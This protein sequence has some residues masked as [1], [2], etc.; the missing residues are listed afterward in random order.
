MCI[1]DRSYKPQLFFASGLACE[2]KGGGRL[3][4]NLF[5]PTKHLFL[6]RYWLSFS[7]A[8]LY[9]SVSPFYFPSSFLSSTFLSLSSF[10][11]I[12]PFVVGN[13]VYQ[14]I[15]TNQLGLLERMTMFQIELLDEEG[16]VCMYL[17]MVWGELRNIK[18]TKRRKASKHVRM[19]ANI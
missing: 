18:S 1:R 2:N 19:H 3:P 12:S 5:Y 17:C 15:S 4:L 9:F 10:P 7:T 6:P 11:V 14:I 13:L 8:L 16:I